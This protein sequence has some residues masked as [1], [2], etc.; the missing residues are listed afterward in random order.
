LSNEAWRDRYEACLQQLRRSEIETVKKWFRPG[1]RVL[2]IG[3]GSGYQARLM[4]SYGCEVSSIDLVD[5]KKPQKLH[6]PVQGYDG[7]HIPFE[8]ASFDLVFSSNVLE[9]V[10]NLPNLLEEMRR[11]LKADGTMVHILPSSTWRFWTSLAHYLYVPLFLLRQR[12]PSDESV[13][14]PVRDLKARY[15]FF[16]LIKNALVSGPHGEYSSAL[17]ELYYFSRGRWRRL[18]KKNHCEILAFLQNGLFYTGYGLFPSLSLAIRKKLA[19]FLGASCHIFVLHFRSLR[20][21]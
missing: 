14:S 13:Q 16:F 9:H 10:K 2:E 19:R 3:G 18:F 20:E 4:A 5:R 11:V 17:S 7:Q 15:S 12:R 6:F 1:M 8:A 21:I